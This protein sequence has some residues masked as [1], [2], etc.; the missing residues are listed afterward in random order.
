MTNNGGQL[1]KL[2]LLTDQIGHLTEVLT[3]GFQDIQTSMHEFCPDIHEIKA[4]V[5][6]Q[7]EATKQQAEAIS[8]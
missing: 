2:D 1:D 6:Q 5:Q 3:I 7:T 4:L 8:Q